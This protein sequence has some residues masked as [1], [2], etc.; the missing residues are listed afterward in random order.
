MPQSFPVA[1]LSYA[2][3]DSFVALDLSSGGIVDAHLNY[4]ILYSHSHS[5]QGPY[6]AGSLSSFPFLKPFLK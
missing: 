6:K 2:A 1:F 3:K 4:P 5:L